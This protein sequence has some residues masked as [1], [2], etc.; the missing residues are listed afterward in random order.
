MKLFKCILLFLIVILL[1]R[2][3]NAKTTGLI[4]YLTP[5]HKYFD[6]LSILNTGA[7]SMQRINQVIGPKGAFSRINNL[8]EYDWVA[9]ALKNDDINHIKQLWK[10]AFI[11]KAEDMFKPVSQGGLGQAKINQLF[12]LNNMDDIL[13][14]DQ[15]I[16]LM[17][18]NT[19]FRNNALK[20]I[21][22]E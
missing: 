6:D 19:A 18:T 14:A 7:T 17:N 5:I 20:F 2:G 4:K 8:N 10:D 22:I 15:F 11:A 1:Q 9:T 21:K 16:L 12:K 3:V 13:D